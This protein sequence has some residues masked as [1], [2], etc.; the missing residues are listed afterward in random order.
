MHAQ[1]HFDLPVMAEGYERVY[2]TLVETRELLDEL[3]ETAAG[4]LRRR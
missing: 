1:A 3:P 2:T 4:S